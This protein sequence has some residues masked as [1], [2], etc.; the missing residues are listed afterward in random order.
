M[1]KLELRHGRESCLCFLPPAAM[2]ATRRPVVRGHRYR[3]AAKQRTGAESRAA[4]ADPETGI[5]LLHS[6]DSAEAAFVLRHHAKQRTGAESRWSDRAAG[7]LRL[8]G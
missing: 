5:K 8:Y 7:I 2:P 3:P 4:Y 1:K 6:T